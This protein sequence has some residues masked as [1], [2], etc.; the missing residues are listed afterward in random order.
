MQKIKIFYVINED[1]GDP[2]GVSL[3]VNNKKHFIHFN[4]EKFIGIR[5]GT[6]PVE[7]DEKG[8]EIKTRTV[9]IWYN[10]RVKSS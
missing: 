10:H 1:S 3:E 4:E 8:K 7:L 9:P 6:F 5:E 2:I